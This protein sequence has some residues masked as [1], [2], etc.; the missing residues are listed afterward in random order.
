L[1]EEAKSAI[2]ALKA[3]LTSAPVLVHADFKRPFVVQCDASHHGVGAVLFQYDEDKNERPIA[4]FSGKLNKHQLNYSVTEKECLAAVLAVEKFRPYV[5][6]MPFTVITDHASL[7]WLM[8]MKDISGRL[9]RWS[10]R[11]Q[12]FDFQIAHR[13]GA[14]NVVADTLS[15]CVEE[16][17]LDVDDAL[18]FATTEFQS[19]EYKEIRDEIRDN[20]ARLPDMRVEG[21]LIFKR[22]GFSRLE[23]EVE[24]GPWKLWIPASLTA[25]MIATAHEDPTSGHGGIKKTL[26]RLQR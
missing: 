13:K 2:Q 19:V 22:L 6:L 20:Q 12:S 1:D 25:G 24:G 9:A 8:T 10:L 26:Q 7:K 23:D 3:A 4:F 16:L 18:G 21:D 17:E 15:R 14:D 5:E 11:L